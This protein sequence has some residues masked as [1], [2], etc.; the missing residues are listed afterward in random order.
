MLP[1]VPKSQP[2]VQTPFC[3]STGSSRGS[4]W[5]GAS[6][7]VHTFRVTRNADLER[8]EE[9]ADDLLDMIS[10]EVRERRSV[11]SP[12]CNIIS[13]FPTDFYAEISIRSIVLHMKLP[14]RGSSGLKPRV[15]RANFPCH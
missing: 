7:E 4:L 10:D 3:G 13:A 9:G 11:P 2:K 8:H 5:W 12:H 15:P 14:V 6:Q 1:C